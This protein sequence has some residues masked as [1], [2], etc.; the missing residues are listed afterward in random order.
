M[1]SWCD[2][3]RPASFRG[4]GFLFEDGDMAGGRRLQVNEYPQSDKP[5][6]EDMGRKA[7]SISLTVFLIGDDYAQQRDQLLA[8]LEKPGDGELVHPRLGSL[9]VFAGDY[10]YSE[11]SSEG[12]MCRFSLSFTEAGEL[13][14][15]TGTT[16]HGASA[17]DLSEQLQASE[18]A[19]FAADLDVSTPE[20]EASA[21]EQ[22]TKNINTGIELI[23]FGVDVAKNLPALIKNPALLVERYFAMYQPDVLGLWDAGSGVYGR[24]MGLFNQSALARSPVVKQLPS[25]TANQVAMA[26]NKQAIDRLHRSVLLA[27]ATQ[28]ASALGGV[29]PVVVHQDAEALRR[30]VLI[31]LDAEESHGATYEVRRQVLS[32]VRANTVQGIKAAQRNAVRLLD[33]A[34]FE[35]EPV[36]LTAY[37]LYGDALRGD[38][39]VTRNKLVHP[40]FVPA[41]PLKVLEK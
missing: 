8:A 1:P 17:A 34:P 40:G 28:V 16:N 13:T 7:R 15:P 14:F 41:E 26:R 2:N 36:V 21:L 12:R 20:L 11:S 19:D 9:K 39:I 10:R 3:L 35:V 4:V 33:V 38:E 25:A 5:F 29:T 24:L 32:A 30:A 37:R 31:Q 6:V 18:T 22:L 27:S 23:N